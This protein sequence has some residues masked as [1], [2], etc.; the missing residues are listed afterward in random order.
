MNIIN[1]YGIYMPSSTNDLA[2]SKILETSS[3][4]DKFV[5]KY[6]DTTNE[7]NC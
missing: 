3:L 2:K 1:I 4:V 7:F 5:E 6:V